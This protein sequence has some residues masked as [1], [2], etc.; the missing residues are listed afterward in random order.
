M[1]EMTNTAPAEV[2]D[3]MNVDHLRIVGDPAFYLLRRGR[4]VRQML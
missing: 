4:F 3:G 2:I 1:P